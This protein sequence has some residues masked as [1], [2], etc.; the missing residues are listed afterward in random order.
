MLFGMLFIV[1]FFSALTC[2]VRAAFS[3]TFG[4]P[5]TV[6]VS[7]IFVAIAAYT[8]VRYIP[9]ISATGIPILVSSRGWCLHW[10]QIYS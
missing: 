5:Y 4:N 10:D 9:I 8:A 1:A 2:L 6:S 3:S 7:S